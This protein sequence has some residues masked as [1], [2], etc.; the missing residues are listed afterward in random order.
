CGKCSVSLWRHL[1]VGKYI[2]A[3][4]RL[5]AGI[6]VLKD[7]RDG[8]GRW[9]RFPFYYTLLALSEMDFAGAIEEMRYV[10][11]ILS[12]LLRRKN[13]IEFYHERKVLLAEKI[14]TKC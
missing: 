4:R 3:E 14:L 11:P 1:L 2:D 13:K 7:H 12:K 6:E 5:E 9:R 10:A 8:K